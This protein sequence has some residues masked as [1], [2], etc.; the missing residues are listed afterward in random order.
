MMYILAFIAGCD[1]RGAC[2]LWSGC[3]DRG[4]KKNRLEMEPLE[5]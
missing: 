3:S 2:G 1:R 5:D 4:F